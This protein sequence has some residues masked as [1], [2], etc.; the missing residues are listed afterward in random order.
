MSS[1]F[2]KAE[3]HRKFW[4]LQGGVV[5]IHN[6][7]AGSWMSTLRNPERFRPGCVAVDEK[8]NE[9]T[10]AGGDDREGAKEWYLTRD[11]RAGS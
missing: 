3:K 10:A 11:E 4:D 8:G 7:K 9:W 1:N 5:V 2:I 6:G